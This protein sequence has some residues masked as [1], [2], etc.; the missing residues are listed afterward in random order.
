MYNQAHYWI[1]KLKIKNAILS[2]GGKYTKGKI[3]NVKSQME[4]Y[5][6][7]EPIENGRMFYVFFPEKGYEKESKEEVFKIIKAAISKATLGNY[8]IL[9]IITTWNELLENFKNYFKED[10]YYEDIAIMKRKTLYAT[11]KEKYKPFNYK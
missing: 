5:N 9:T 2:Y 11:P 1:N 4:N 3:E 10:D 6:E 7:I 8:Y